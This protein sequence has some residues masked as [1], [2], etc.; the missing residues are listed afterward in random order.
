VGAV[1]V[2]YALARFFGRGAVSSV[3]HP[4]MRRRENLGAHFCE[5][6]PRHLGV[7]CLL[8]SPGP[9]RVHDR[10]VALMCKTR[11]C[12]QRQRGSRPFSSVAFAERSVYDQS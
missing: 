3:G 9:A 5:C 6:S 10:A 12:A 11:P 8:V 4:H 2:P 1:P 7:V